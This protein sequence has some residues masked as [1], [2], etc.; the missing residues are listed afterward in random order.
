MTN[1]PAGDVELHPIV[2]DL[3]ASMQRS[4][5]KTLIAIPPEVLE[6]AR[7]RVRSSK[8]ADVLTHLVAL[9]VKINRLAGDGGTPAIAALMLLVAEKL[10]SAQDAADRFSAAGISNAAQLLGVTEAARAPREQPKPQ[11]AVKPKRGLSK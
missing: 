9:A 2:A 3:A 10:G 5:D 7:A 1:A 11:A 4:P 6:K 8:D